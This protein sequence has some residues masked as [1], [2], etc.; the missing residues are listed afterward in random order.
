MEA[1]GATP[2]ERLRSI[3]TGFGV[4]PK[5]KLSHSAKPADGE[6]SK[7]AKTAR[8]TAAATRPV[9]AALPATPVFLADEPAFAEAL[10]ALDHLDAAFMATIRAA[11]DLPRLRRR[12]PGFAGLAQIIVSQQV[13]TASANAIFG[14]LQ[15]R[16]PVLVARA[17]LV[18][19]DEDLRSCGL[20]APKIRT[21]RAI[22]EA[23]RDGHLD[24]GALAEAE[25][26]TAH[27]TLC[28]IKGI[29]P[30]TADIFLLFCLGHGD[31]WPVGDLALQEGARLALGL[32]TRPD[33]KALLAIGER[34]RPL[35]G[36][37]AHCL[38]AHYSHRRA[39]PATLEV[40]PASARSRPDKAVA[41]TKPPPKTTAKTGKA[42]A[43]SRK[44]TSRKATKR[45]S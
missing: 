2:S 45:T 43:T 28:A 14:R 40:T 41:R 38:W 26:E 36:V 39:R 37:V 8:R 1:G 32:A 16:L 33:A 15:A 9:R 25:A 13:S 27:T 4:P 22:A 21:L 23:V 6:P 42:P 5:K 20:S 7:V 12:E 34:W 24:F 35:R 3:L 29:G 30:W 18:T 19:S 10:A 44:T 17:I 31:A 11:G